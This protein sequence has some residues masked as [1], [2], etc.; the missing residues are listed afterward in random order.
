[1]LEWI[2][3]L[4]NDQSTNPAQPMLLQ[5][6]R[7]RALLHRQIYEALKAGIREGKYRP[8]TRLSTRSLCA[9]PACRATR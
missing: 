2:W 3:I 5:L 1:L 6:R 4:Q 7:S 9:T 8:G